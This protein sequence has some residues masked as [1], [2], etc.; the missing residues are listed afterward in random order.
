MF[1]K[2]ISLNN[3]TKLIMSYNFNPQIKIQLKS[4]IQDL[5]ALV[6]CFRGFGQ[7]N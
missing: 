4:N 5:A 1:Y 2:T 7:Y 6:E 3:Y